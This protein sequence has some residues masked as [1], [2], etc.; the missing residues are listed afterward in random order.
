MKH[1]SLWGLGLVL[2]FLGSAAMACVTPQELYLASDQ[3]DAEHENFNKAFSCQALTNDTLEVALI[4]LGRVGGEKA[5]NRVLP[6]LSHDSA[7][8][9]EAAV[10]ALGI[11]GV[12]SMGEH[13]T[14]ALKQEKA[15]TVKYQMAL[16]IGNM[17]YSQAQQILTEII[18]QSED[19]Q[20]IRGAL[21]GLINL[22][23]FHSSRLGSFENLS[24]SQLYKA[25]WQQETQLEASYLMARRN[26]ME[27]TQVNSALKELDKLPP[28]VQAKMVRALGNTQLNKV[29][30]MLLTHIQK[31][32]IGIRV[33]AIRGLADFPDNPAAMAGVL[34]ALKQNDTVSQVTALQTLHNDW[35]DNDD[36]YQAVTKKLSSN[37]SWV[38]SE[39]LMVLIRANKADG[40]TTQ[41]WVNSTDPNLQRAAIAYFSKL[42]DEDQLQQ[43]VKSDKAI[44]ARG[45][46][47]ALQPERETSG[48]PSNTPE[49]LPDVDSIVL[50]N[51]TQGPITI[52]LYADTPYT[53]A[54]FIRLVN[55]GYYDN[56]YFHRVIPDF[57]AQGGSN[58]GDGSGSVDY[59]IR[60]ELS[61][62]SHLP[63][64]VGMAT[65]GKDTGG[66]Q[67]FINTAPN[68]HL[69]S[70]YTI[71]GKVVEGMDNAMQ[72]EQNDKVIS[73]KIVA[74]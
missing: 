7:K 68:L 13:L 66:G 22:S 58:I 34:I 45:A 55:D 1:L 21:Q 20:E 72:L 6:Y 33:N 46:Q 26:L 50:L 56:S 15:P 61:Y 52:Q 69:D 65:L 27:M 59:S 37:N 49:E 70:N 51:T 67:F 23:S 5:A 12:P 31:E 63:G 10:F 9:R 18:N 11:A 62:R 41:K 17:G 19:S 48:E 71:F 57:V 47:Q 36:V 2:S 54:N 16:A 3:R 4:A 73:A 74:D 32:H 53:S 35:L 44:I 39:A 60:E 25:L 40:D 30:P 42:Q 38:Q 64:T 29:L 43:L 14:S 24:S 8:V 28:M